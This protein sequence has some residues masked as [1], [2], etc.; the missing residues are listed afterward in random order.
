VPSQPSI[1]QKINHRLKFN[2]YGSACNTT[3][4]RHIGPMNDM[5]EQ[6]Q[7]K[8][9]FDIAKEMTISSS[10]FSLHHLHLELYS[11]LILGLPKIKETISTNKTKRLYL[12]DDELVLL[13]F[14]QRVFRNLKIE[15]CWSSSSSSRNI[16]MRSIHC[17]FR[18][19]KV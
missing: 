8:Y 15:R 13:S 5:I 17:Q 16:V 6:K 4:G 14:V 11:D 19:D 10:S 18:R 3:I 12:T 7:S 1:D 2:T 9:I